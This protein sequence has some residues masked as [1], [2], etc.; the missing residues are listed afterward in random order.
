MD[1]ILIRSWTFALRAEGL[2]PRTIYNYRADMVRFEQTVDGLLTTAT[3]H[4]AREYIAARLEVSPYCA[5]YAWRSLR[6]FYRWAAS[7]DECPDITVKIRQPKTPLRPTKSVSEEQ[8]RRLIAF[9]TSDG[10]KGTRDAAMLFVLW[11]TG[12]RRTELASLTVDDINLD[13]QTILVRESKNGEYRVVYLTTPA[14][15]QLMAWL[16]ARTKLPMA[17]GTSALWVGRFGALSSDG[18]RQ[19]IER[20]AKAAD[21]PVSAHCFRRSLAERWLMAGG[22]EGALMTTAG[23]RNS[24]MARRYSRGATQAIA[25]SEFKRVIGA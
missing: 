18:V 24:T 11:S 10:W 19:A 2:S 23:W 7:E 1:S 15:K 21:V 16:R 3:V 8:F 20:R 9:C 13:Q 5:N 4:H 22:G 6:S 12:L 25:A 14:T 17:Q